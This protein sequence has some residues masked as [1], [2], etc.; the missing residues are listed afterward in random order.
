MTFAV[1]HKQIN[2][3]VPYHEPDLLRSIITVRYYG[4]GLERFCT[5]KY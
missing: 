1:E 2:N 4:P 5:G 3:N